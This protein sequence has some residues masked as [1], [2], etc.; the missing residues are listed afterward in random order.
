M[1]ICDD[2][3]RYY[4]LKMLKIRIPLFLC[5]GKGEEECHILSQAS[6]EAKVREAAESA[7]GKGRPPWQAGRQI[8]KR[9]TAD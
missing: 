9:K 5:A 6:E 2:N 7:D 8:A 4:N 1:Y 3:G